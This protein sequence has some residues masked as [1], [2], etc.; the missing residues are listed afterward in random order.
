VWLSKPRNN[1]LFYRLARRGGDDQFVADFSFV[2]FSFVY[3]DLQKTERQ[4]N[5]FGYRTAGFVGKFAHFD[6]GGIRQIQ[7]QPGFAALRG[8]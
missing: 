4:S 3:D 1:Q 2:Y 7:I 6:A 8:C 5:E